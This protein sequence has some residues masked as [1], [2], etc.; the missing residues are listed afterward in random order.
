MFFNKGKELGTSLGLVFARRMMAIM[1]LMVP[2]RAVEALASP[3]GPN[4]SWPGFTQM[5]VQGPGPV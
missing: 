2:L 1:A 5:E 3:V 4:T